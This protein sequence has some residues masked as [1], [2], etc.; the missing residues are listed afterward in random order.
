MEQQHQ[1]FEEIKLLSEDGIEY[2]S[3]R[4]LAPLLDYRDWR[5]FLKVLSKALQACEASN[6]EPSYHFVEANKMVTLGSGAERKIDDI[7]LSRYACYLVVQN[8]DPSKP[9]IAAGQTYF[10]IQTRRQ[11]LADD[12]TFRRLRED[13]KRLFLRNELKEHNKQ[14]VETAQRAG[15][16]TNIDFAIFQN[17]GYQGLYGGLDQK[18][19]HQ[20]KGLKKTQRILDHMGSTEL[21]A[22]LFRATQAEEKLRRDNVKG[23]TQANQTHFDVGRKV[24]DTIQELG[25]TMPEDLPSPE[26]SIKQLE[27][28]AKKKLKK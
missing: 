3:A 12:A 14:L 20:R 2:W 8:G 10:A 17:H 28:M 26:K 6:Q 22:N 16:E 19:I 15:V 23:K 21:A 25:G 1:L 27:T 18:A 11:E 5:N 9:V 13:E 4:D 24:R 7:K